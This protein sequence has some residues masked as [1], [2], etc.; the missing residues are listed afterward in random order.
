MDEYQ[1]AQ[2]SIMHYSNNMS[3]QEIAK[4]LGVSKM[5]IS[6][7][8]Q[9]AKEQEIVKISVELPFDL[10]ER[11]SEQLVKTYGLRRAIVVKHAAENLGNVA[12]ILGRVWAFYLGTT[13]LDK[14]ILGIGVG[15]TLAQIVHYLPEMKTS[16]LHVVQLMGGLSNVTSENPITLIQETCRKLSANG[17]YVTSTAT[18]EDKK[19]RDTLLYHTA[20]G[21]RVLEL[22]QQCHIALFGVGAIERGTLLSPDLVSTDELKNLKQT[23]A[24]GD[25]LGHCFDD[26]GNFIATELEDRLIS[27]P[28]SLLRS[29]QDRVA[30]AGGE[31]KVNA[32][33]ATLRSGIVTTLVTDDCTGEL[34]LKN[35][36]L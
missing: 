14:N 19:L 17:T 9:K 36:L 24:I 8:L 6:R 2:I 27:I 18:V 21:Q 22:W 15:N 31:Y 11:I 29:I 35:R 30:V 4:S 25:I 33:R 34:L 32:I 16:D 3:Q 23:G 13:R 5:T 7:M 1:L 10:D 20:M 28:L 12:E 26:K